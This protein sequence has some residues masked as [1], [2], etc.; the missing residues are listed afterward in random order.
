MS[1]QKFEK[2]ANIAK[3]SWFKKIFYRPA[4]GPISKILEMIARKSGCIFVW[5]AKTFWGREMTT[6]IPDP[7]SMSII[8]YG[9]FEEFFT[10][11]L[12]DRIKPGMIFLDVGAHFGFFT[13][14]SAHLVGDVGQVHSFEPTPHTFAILKKNAAENKNVTLNNVAVYS[15][16]SSLKFIDYG[17]A[18]ACLNRSTPADLCRH[19]LPV[20][21]KGTYIS[22]TI[23]LDEYCE[24][25]NIKPDFVKLDA[26]GAEEE[27]LKGANRLI[28]SVRPLWS[29][30]VG[31]QGTEEYKN[32]DNIIQILLKENYR[33]FKYDD[34]GELIT[35]REGEDWGKENLLFIPDEKN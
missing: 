24:E 32:T 7:V 17:L 14:L 13:L 26:E 6:V 8:R 29:I 18:Y 23:T 10:R 28:S 25:K 19:K 2:S 4:V 11:T 21:Q 5:K 16:V 20:V 1:K 35:Y 34:Q 33:V 12:L 27:I 9:F 31:S 3:S 15:H 22:K 30:E